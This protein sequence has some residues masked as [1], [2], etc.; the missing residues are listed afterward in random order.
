[1]KRSEF[2]TFAQST[3]R[4]NTFVTVESN[5]DARLRK[6]GCPFVGVRKLT[7]MNGQIGF[8]YGENVNAMAEKEGK[9]RR[10]SKPRAWGELTSDRLFVC[11]DKGGPATQKLSPPSCPPNR[12]PVPK[13]TSTGK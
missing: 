11:K 12:S 7:T 10:E 4:G 1:M 8:D 13:L 2:I 3:V 5:T 6:T 9:E